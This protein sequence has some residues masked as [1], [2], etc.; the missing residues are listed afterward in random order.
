M[1]MIVGAFNII[2]AIAAISKDKVFVG[3]GANSVLW[4]DLTAWGWVH[5]ILGVA[6]VLVGIGLTRGS[7]AAQITAV[8]LVSVNAIT[9]LAFL[10]AYPIL[11]TVIIAADVITLWALIVHGDELRLS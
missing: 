7:I 8:A 11:A 5:L 10:T 3:T 4:L 2:D 1:L 9:Q 6:Q